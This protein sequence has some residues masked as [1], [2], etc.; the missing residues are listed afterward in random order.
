MVFIY[1]LQLEENKYY[2]GKTHDPKFRLETHFDS[3][4][5]AWTK[6]YKPVNIHAVIPDCDDYDE[7]KYVL[8]YM[9]EK[10][11][12]N[13]RGGSFSQIQLNS[14]NESTIKKMI[15]SSDDK[16]HNCGETGHFMNKCDKIKK[17]KNIKKVTEDRCQRCNRTGHNEEKCYAKTYEN[18]DEISDFEIISDYEEEFY[19]CEYCN[20]EFDTLKGATFHENMYCK[21]KYTKIQKNN[22]NGSN[23]SAIMKIGN[24]TMYKCDYC[25][26]GF[27][28][29]NLFIKHKNICRKK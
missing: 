1:V 4:G 24:I 15:N 7:D 14:E 17:T 5:S 27:G 19:V 28:S 11:I 18:G 21:K 26:T 9:S 3:K 8:K 20:K 2:I 23:G 12:D 22:M 10:G 13:V 6:K 16:C 25:N 29:M